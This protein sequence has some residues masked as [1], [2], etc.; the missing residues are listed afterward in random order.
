MRAGDRDV[1]AVEDHEHVVGVRPEPVGRVLLV[2][3]VPARLQVAGHDGAVAA[4][5]VMTVAAGDSTN[6]SAPPVGLA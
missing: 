1:G 6:D 2:Q 3:A 4:Q 5:I